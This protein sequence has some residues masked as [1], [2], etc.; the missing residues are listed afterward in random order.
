MHRT[1]CEK[2]DKESAAGTSAILRISRKN[3]IQTSRML[4]NKS[5]RNQAF[6][7]RQFTKSLQQ[8]Y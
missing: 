3:D 6:V 7:N 8:G 1:S 5:L 2:Q 4:Y